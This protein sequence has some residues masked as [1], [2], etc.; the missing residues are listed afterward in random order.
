MRFPF[1]PFNKY[2]SSKAI[3]NSDD[4]ILG[5]LASAQTHTN[6]VAECKRQ[7]NGRNFDPIK[8]MAYFTWVTRVGFD[9]TSGIYSPSRNATITLIGIVELYNRIEKWATRPPDVKN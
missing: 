6:T 7:W 4:I 2:G 9:V 1:A 3:K 8:L 5:L